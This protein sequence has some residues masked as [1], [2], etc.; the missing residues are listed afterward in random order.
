MSSYSMLAFA[1]IIVMYSFTDVNTYLEQ[2]SDGIPEALRPK[3]CQHC[4]QSIRL[5]R[6]GKFF[7]TLFTLQEEIRIPIFRFYCPLCE[8]CCSFLPEFIEPHQQVALDVQEEVLIAQQTH[9][10][11]A[12]SELTLH[13]PGGHFSEKTLWRWTCKWN[14]RLDTVEPKLWE[15]LLQRVP[16]IELPSRMKR[17]TVWRFLWHQVCSSSTM[18]STLLLFWIRQQFHSLALADCVEFPT[19]PVHGMEAA[20]A[21]Q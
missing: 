10:L 17:W 7:R 9:T 5:H 19:K 3:V 4:S 18:A 13:F 8:G 2:C 14:R 15:W 20:A 1:V 6:H 16:H 11:A 21:S 12:L